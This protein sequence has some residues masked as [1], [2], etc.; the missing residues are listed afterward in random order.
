MKYFNTGCKDREN[1]TGVILA[2][3]KSSRYQKLRHKFLDK[4][5]GKEIIKIVLEAM[6][7]LVKEL[8]CVVSPD[9]EEIKR[10]LREYPS[11]K[12]AIQEKPLGTGDALLA[13]APLLEGSGKDILVS[14]ADK[15]LVTSRTFFLL[16]SHHF[17]SQAHITFA[18]TIL[19]D[20]GSKGRIIR[21][22]GKFVDIIEARDA[23]EETKMDVARVI[24]EEHEVQ[25]FAIDDLPDDWVCPICGASKDEFEVER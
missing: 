18:T 19:P 10:T 15:P 1:L 20:P 11:I 24:L 17:Q 21:K 13:T 22:E 16:I 5:Q 4:F 6:L 8:I 23:D 3:G 9:H 2:A 14:F 25:V 12:Y 7:P